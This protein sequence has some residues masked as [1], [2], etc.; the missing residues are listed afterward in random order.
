MAMNSELGAT[1]SPAGASSSRDGPWQQ[2]FI[3]FS[4]PKPC[5]SRDDYRVMDKMR[6]RYSLPGTPFTHPV[7]SIRALIG[8]I[9]E[10][11]DKVRLLRPQQVED[12]IIIE[13]PPL[14]IK[15][16]I[17]RAILDSP[18][19]RIVL[20]NIYKY[21]TDNFAYYRASE[22]WRNTVR[23]TLSTCPVFTQG[24]P[25][26]IYKTGNFWMIAPGYE[27]CI[28]LRKFTK[29]QRHMRRITPAGGVRVVVDIAGQHSINVDS[30][31]DS[32]R[33]QHQPE[34]RPT[35]LQLR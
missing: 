11:S 2:S 29:G 27:G 31:E 17:L 7:F 14:I 18:K 10:D 34:P 23:Y 6:R 4:D 20:S 19:N 1:S 5:L 13:K 21:A 33:M 8:E 35:Q 28:S 9:P 32:W 22:G 26:I 15:D 3:D 12:P 25:K 24:N 16:L 30:C